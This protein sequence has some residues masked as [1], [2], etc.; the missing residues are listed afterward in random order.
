MNQNFRLKFRFF[1]T[2]KEKLIFLKL[3]Y[4]KNSIMNQK[5]RQKFGFFL[6]KKN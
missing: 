5:F 4:D 3:I 6:N 1:R 2:N